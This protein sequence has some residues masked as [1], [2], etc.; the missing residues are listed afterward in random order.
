MLGLYDDHAAW[1]LART[2]GHSETILQDGHILLDVV[3]HFHTFTAAL[4]R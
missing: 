3:L 4:R 2:K 1:R